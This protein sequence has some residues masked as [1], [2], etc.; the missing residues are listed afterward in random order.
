MT[1]GV[2][3]FESEFKILQRNSRSLKNKRRYL[4][5]LSETNKLGALNFALNGMLVALESALPC[6][7]IVPFLTQGP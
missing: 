1:S 7:S 5:L 4:C 6:I 2:I 3:R